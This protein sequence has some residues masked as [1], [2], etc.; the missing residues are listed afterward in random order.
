MRKR[1]SVSLILFD[2]LLFD[3]GW[4]RIYLLGVDPGSRGLGKVIIENTH[5]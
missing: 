2:P 1:G 4:A 5:A 3:P